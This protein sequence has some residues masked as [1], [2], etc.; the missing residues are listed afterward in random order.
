MEIRHDPDAHTLALKMCRNNSSRRLRERE[1][2]AR[3]RRFG[4]SSETAAAAQCEARD[5][6]FRLALDRRQTAAVTACSMRGLRALDKHS[7]ARHGRAECRVREGSAQ[8]W[9]RRTRGR[10]RSNLTRLLS[11]NG[12][13]LTGDAAFRSQAPPRSR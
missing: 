8:I 9:R 4:T 13:T 7:L 3:S 6:D 10:S 5:K 2:P 11:V 1:H 12:A